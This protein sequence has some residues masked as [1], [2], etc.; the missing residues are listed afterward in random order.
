MSLGVH[1]GRGSPQPRRSGRGRGCARLCP[2]SRGCGVASI[3]LPLV[4]ML[5][6]AP[7]AAAVDGR[8]HATIEITADRILYEAS[9]QVYVA[10]GSVRVVQQGRSIESDWAVFNRDTLRGIAAG[11]VVMVDGEQTLE[12]NF[13]E[14]DYDL[15][16]GLVF[17]GRLEMG[18]DEFVVG[19]AELLKTGELTYSARDASFTTCRCPDPDARLPWQLNTEDA[20]VEIGGY[21]TATNLSPFWLPPHVRAGCSRNRDNR[22]IGSFPSASRRMC[23]RTY[24][25]RVCSD[26]SNDSV[27]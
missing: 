22:K 2:G 21:A 19:A 3:A 18:E 7:P 10:E 12:A 9:R 26:S 1:T 23:L 16:Q 13:V 25:H 27:C 15:Q 5:A 11:D 6:A 8:D 20:D 4:C 24:R 17:G 14:F